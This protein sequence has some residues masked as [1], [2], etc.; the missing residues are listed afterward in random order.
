MLCGEPKV[1]IGKDIMS[2]S[3]VSVSPSTSNTADHKF[4]FSVKFGARSHDNLT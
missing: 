2:A 3:D 4:I 1:S